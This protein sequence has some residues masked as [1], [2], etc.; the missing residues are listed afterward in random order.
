MA[1]YSVPAFAGDYTG[2]PDA[3]IRKRAAAPTVTD[4]HIQ[5]MVKK[6]LTEHPPAAPQAS[7]SIVKNSSYAVTVT[8]APYEA[9]P[10]GKRDATKAIQDAIN[11]VY[12]L[13]GGSVYIPAGKYLVSYPFIEL[14]GFVHVYGDDRATE[15]IEANRAF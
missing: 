13:G 4:E 1:T 8:H 10:T 6:Y 2:K 15:I 14:K 5:N 9:D 11:D 12:A 7:S 3:A